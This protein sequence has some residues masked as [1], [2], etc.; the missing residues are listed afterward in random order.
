MDAYQDIQD[1][2][3]SHYECIAKTQ[4]T[5][6]LIDLKTDV[7]EKLNELDGWCSNEKALILMDMVINLKPNTIVEIGVFGGKSL[8]PMAFALKFN[9]KGKAYGVDPWSSLAS[10]EG[11]EGVNLDW[12]SSVDHDLIFERLNEKISQFK[13]K[14]SIELIRSTSE[15]CPPIENIDI[16]HIDG[17]H[18]EKA[19]Y[20]DVVKWVP[21]V[22]SGGI[23]IFDD[24]NWSTTKLAT[25]WLNDHCTKLAEYKGDN[26]WG[27]WVKP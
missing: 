5:I 10:S 1:Y 19:S 26:I 2:N 12:W 9:K 15:N 21:L 18:S 6:D 25:E 22:K 27:V 24:V 4:A 16:L 20:I 11:M 7:L 13:L 14:N 23:I 17:N 8:I 3:P